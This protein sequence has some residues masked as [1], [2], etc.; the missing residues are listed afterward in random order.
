VVD[1]RPDD[2]FSLEVDTA[3]PRIVSLQQFWSKPESAPVPGPGTLALKSGAEA[4]DEDGAATSSTY[5]FFKVI[6]AK[7]I[8]LKGVP[9]ALGA[10]RRLGGDHLAVS[11]HHGV[12]VPNGNGAF[13]IAS[14]ASRTSDDLDSIALLTSLGGNVDEVARSLLAWRRQGSLRF[15][16]KGEE[17][18]D[19]RADLLTDLVNRAG[20]G[21]SAYQPPTDA[22]ILQQL[23]ADDLVAQQG[24]RFALVASAWSRI[25]FSWHV[26]SPQRV[27]QVRPRVPL[28]D[29][30]S[31]EL[32]TMLGEAGFEWKALP[33]GVAR[34]KALPGHVPG[35]AE[36]VWYTTPKT[37]SKLYMRALLQAEDLVTKRKLLVAIPH[38]RPDEFYE[39]L[40]KGKVV[41][42]AIAAQL[43]AITAGAEECASESDGALEGVA[44]NALD[45][46][47]EDDRLGAE[48]G[49]WE[50]VSKEEMDKIA[51]E[52]FGD[53]GSDGEGAGLLAAAEAAEGAAVVDVMGSVA[54]LV[55]MLDMEDEQQLGFHTP[56]PALSSAPP[57]V[58]GP[59]PPVDL[60]GV[61]PEAVPRVRTARRAR[62]PVEGEVEL[63]SWKVNVFRLTPKEGRLKG[64]GGGA[65]G[66]Y[67][68]ACP[69][70][71][72][73]SK[74]G[75]K[76]WSPCLGPTPN[77]RRIA[78]RR[79]LVIVSNNHNSR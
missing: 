18:N 43:P 66:G 40:L 59:P 54:G 10:R 52:L 46:I 17:A 22:E 28:Q 45:D 5:L 62:P 57:P 68:A 15:H 20:V 26:G 49:E 61:A 31:Y 34:R 11:V 64:G 7:P 4:L 56:G 71:A 65:H 9:V 73:S 8:N 58:P 47:P 23:V 25:G 67:E 2:I 48:D 12:A 6:R 77:D 74:T 13:S 21:L 63:R 41:S 35:T 51:A 50:D 16:L 55:D 69:F 79:A 39:N 37:A 78:L 19:R 14:S 36:R 33:N 38:G 42:E 72:K 27:C 30:T 53:S 3:S 1:E 70:H 29:R 24:G 32:M 44:P 76:K 75:C 60:D